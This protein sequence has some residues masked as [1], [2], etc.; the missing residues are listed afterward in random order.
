MEEEDLEPRARQAPEPVE[1]LAVVLPLEMLGPDPVIEEIPEED[2]A[3]ERGPAALH[4]GEESPGR[5]G[6]S[7]AQVNVARKEGAGRVT[8]S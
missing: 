4:E 1:R 7:R 3:V 8:S 2:E 6:V 5:S